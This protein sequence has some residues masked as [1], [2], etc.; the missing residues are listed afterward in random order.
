MGEILCM[1]SEFYMCIPVCSHP[2]VKKR[3]WSNTNISHRSL[4][5]QGL[6]FV[7][8]YI[9]KG[10]SVRFTCGGGPCL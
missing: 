10:Q 4:G 7:Y 2:H 1:L 9:Y 6:G 8:I 5:I 3:D